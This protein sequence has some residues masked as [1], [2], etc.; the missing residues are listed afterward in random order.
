MQPVTVD[1]RRCPNCGTPQGPQ[2]RTAIMWIGAAGLLA[3]LFVVGIMLRS[4][5]EEDIENS[6]PQSTT[7]SSPSQPDKPPPLNQ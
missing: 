3:L 1:T 2:S 6:S 4:I 7:Q 5:W